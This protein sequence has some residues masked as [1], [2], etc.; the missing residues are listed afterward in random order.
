[1]PVGQ[2][3]RSFSRLVAQLCERGVRRNR[4]NSTNNRS[5]S[6]RAVD[7]YTGIL[8]AF[9]PRVPVTY[10][11]L[12]EFEA[13][14]STFGSPFD[15]RAQYRYAAAHTRVNC[16]LQYGSD[17]MKNAIVIATKVGGGA[18]VAGFH[19]TTIISQM[20]RRV[21]ALYECA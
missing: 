13:L 15:Q 16:W 18:A 3:E 1:M 6:R 10:V 19:A 4:V 20:Y 8:R 7:G 9:V 21:F 11:Y 14:L 17:W 12:R 5:G 2:M